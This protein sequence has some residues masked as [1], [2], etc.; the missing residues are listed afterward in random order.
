MKEKCGQIEESNNMGRT[1]ELF[2]EIKEM[3]GSDSARCGTMKLSTGKV[4]TARR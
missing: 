3:T 2:R 4:V 1:I